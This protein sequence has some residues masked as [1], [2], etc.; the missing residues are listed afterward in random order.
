M[1]EPLPKFDAPPVVET[2]LSVQF[3]PLIGYTTS[4]AGWFWKSYLPVLTDGLQWQKAIDA[5]RLDDALERFGEK[6]AWGRMG[7]R[8]GQVGSTPN[9]VQIIQSGE[10]RMVQVQDSRFILNW[11]KGGEEPYPSF[12]TLS[13]EF[14]KIFPAF[15]RFCVDAGLGDVQQNQWEVTYVN[16]VPRGELWQNATELRKIIPQLSLPTGV[17]VA[18]VVADPISLDWRFAFPNDRGRLYI[19]AVHARS[20]PDFSS[21]EFIQIT[22]TARGAVDHD[23]DWDLKSGFDL[24]H[25]AIVRTFTAMT[26]AEAHKVWKRRI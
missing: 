24:G 14:W 1:A 16:R 6:E 26:S 23:K 17:A 25:D 21:D 19:G 7:I 9:R 22:C 5:P 2:A 15:E 10:R 20:S 11:R 3:A 8:F 13:Q 12:D 4:M 18:A